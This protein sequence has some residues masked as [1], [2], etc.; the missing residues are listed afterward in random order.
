MATAARLT[1][2]QQTDLADARNLATA[3]ATGSQAIGD[4]LGTTREPEPSV[5]YAYAL[6]RAG[7]SINLLLGIIYDLQGKGV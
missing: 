3:I 4:Y 1:P 6:A 7:G 2:Q 5:F